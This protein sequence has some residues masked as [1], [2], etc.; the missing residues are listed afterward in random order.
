MRPRCRAIRHF[1]D[2]HGNYRRSLRL[3]RC[4]HKRQSSGSSLTSDSSSLPLSPFFFLFPPLPI[5]FFQWM[6]TKFES[7]NKSIIAFLLGR[8]IQLGE[9]SVLRLCIVSPCGRA[10]TATLK[11]NIPLYCPPSHAI[12]KGGWLVN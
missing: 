6:P 2:C 1:L 8:T 4:L 11:L 9:Y 10:N 12:R 7:Y 3:E 5:F